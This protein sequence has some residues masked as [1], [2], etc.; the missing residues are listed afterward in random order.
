MK[1]CS[2][3]EASKAPAGPELRLGLDFVPWPGHDHITAMVSIY[4]Y[5]YVY[6][7]KEYIYIFIFTYI[8]IYIYIIQPWSRTILK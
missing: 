6:K 4:I 2:P 1:P 5:T 3:C 8:F 7:Y